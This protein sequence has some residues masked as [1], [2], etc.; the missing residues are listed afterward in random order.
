[1]FESREKPELSVTQ[2][3]EGV[4]VLTPTLPSGLTE[5]QGI[6]AQRMLLDTYLATY[7][8]QDFVAW[9]YTPMAL[10]FSDH[11]SPSKV[12]YDCMDELSAFQG[13]PPALINQERRLF[14][15]SDVV[16]VGGASLYASKRTQH[17]NAH[18][19]PSSIDYAHFAAARANP[20]DP[21]DQTD[22]PHPR[23]GFYGVL[24]ERL[25]RNLL[26]E[27]ASLRPEWHFILIGPI[28]KISEADLPRGDNLHYLGQKSYRE[29]PA[30]LGN[31]DVAMLPFA[32][33]SSTQFI[34]PT[35][36][37]EY[38]AGARPVVSTPITDVVKPYGE[39]HLVHIGATV[40]EFASA[41]EQALQK[42]DETWLTQV[43]E[44]LAETSWDK[45]FESMWKEIQR[46][47]SPGPASSATKQY[48]TEGAG[49]DV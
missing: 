32:R 2:T 24:D 25:D 42:R 1:M 18:L 20:Q 6:E 47:K 39:M 26:K 10:R 49:T 40:E 28:V 8:V 38:L 15:R 9:Y 17:S 13:A 22:I 48:I 43:D 14:E 44:F 41:I 3:A 34:S 36:T 46:C 27:I 12:V 19:F 33:N 31:W 37:P 35:K 30:Y 21:A 11:L 29:L 7:N 16:F 23:I 5:E 45:T 4:R